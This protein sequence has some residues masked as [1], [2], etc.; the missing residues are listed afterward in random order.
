MKKAVFMI[1]AALLLFSTTTVQA[2]GN[3]IE[4]RF[5]TTIQGVLSSGGEQWYRV[6][7]NS[8]SF[9]VV[10]TFGDIDTMMEAYDDANTLLGYDDDG[11]EDYNARMEIFIE[12]GRTYF[13]KVK[14]FGDTSGPYSI[15]AV[16]KPIPR[17]TELRPGAALRSETL[18][19]RE[20]HWYSVRAPGSGFVVV[21]TIGNIDTFLEVYSDAYVLLTT[22]D[23]GGDDT[24][25]RAE[26]FVES[27]KTYYFKLRGY[28]SD[29]SGSYRIMASFET[30]PEDT[31]R[32]TD[33]SRA[34]ALRLGEAIPVFLRTANESRWYRYQMSG[35]AVLIVQ[36]RGD[37]DTIMIL[38]DSNGNVITEDDDSGEDYNAMISERLNAGTYFIEIK[39]YSGE[40]GRFTLHAETR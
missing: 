24:N 32:N 4:L 15:Q 39:Q 2:Q 27:G 7:H 22:N 37:T 3:A 35:S 33:R 11:G 31:E 29:I 1:Y 26:V 20:D 19:A 6:R 30:V 8:N 18:R 16:L 25:A 23:D 36:T 10:E 5:G 34:A 28:S 9:V 13:F 40:M 21:E 14:G 17:P 12:S 38:Y